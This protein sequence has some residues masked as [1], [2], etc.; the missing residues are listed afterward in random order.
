MKPTIN[1]ARLIA[2]G[3]PYI[4]VYKRLSMG[5]DEDRAYTPRERLCECGCQGVGVVPVGA[6]L[7][8]LKTARALTRTVRVPEVRCG[9]VERGIEQFDLFGWT[10]PDVLNKE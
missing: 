2:S 8:C 1:T 3:L 4:L 7:Y 5:W 6:R 9:A 10:S